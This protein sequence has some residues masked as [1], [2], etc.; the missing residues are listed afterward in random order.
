MI[1]PLLLPRPHNRLFAADPACSVLSSHAV[2]PS[3]KNRAVK[4]TKMSEAVPAC[5]NASVPVYRSDDRQ[6][7]T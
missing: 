3:E 4:S 6:R 7:E 2:R 1:A 5:S